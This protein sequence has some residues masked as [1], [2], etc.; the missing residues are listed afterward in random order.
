MGATVPP[1]KF[2]LTS[3]LTHKPCEVSEKLFARIGVF[4]SS[5]PLSPRRE[6]AATNP[7]FR[8]ERKAIFMPNPYQQQ[9]LQARLELLL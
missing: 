2:S 3:T 6:P 1:F 8:A 9:K 7:H 4:T 5:T